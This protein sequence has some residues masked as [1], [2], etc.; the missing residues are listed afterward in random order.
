MCRHLCRHGDGIVAL[1]AMA[2]LPLPMCRHLA[3]VDDDGDGVT[4][5]SFETARWMVATMTT[6]TMMVRLTTTTTETTT[7]LMAAVRWTTR[8][9][10]T[11]T[12]AMDDSVDDN[13]DNSDDD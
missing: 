9:M 3:V 2:S 4:G 10:T 12:I 1:V 5:D 11:V 13:D 6:T 8:T 7:T